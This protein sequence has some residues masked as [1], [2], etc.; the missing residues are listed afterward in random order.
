MKRLAILAAV[1]LALSL[2]AQET[3]A[4][5]LVRTIPLPDVHGRI[6]HLALDTRGHRLFA[7]ALGNDTVEVIDLAAGKCI[8]TIG[9]C[10]E[11]QG[12]AFVPAE[13]RLVIAHG[14]NGVV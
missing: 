11:P 12:L 3:N 13:N 14:G 10:S 1:L 8:R 9:G 6:D 7:A 2:R 4:L 5:T